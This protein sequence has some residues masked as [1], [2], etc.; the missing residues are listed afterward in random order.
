MGSCGNK[1]GALGL[2]ALRRVNETRRPIW[3]PLC[4]AYRSKQQRYIRV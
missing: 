2:Y 4:L 1:H 3:R